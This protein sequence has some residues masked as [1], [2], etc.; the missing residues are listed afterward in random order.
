MSDHKLISK[1]YTEYKPL[2][3][4]NRILHKLNTSFELTAN[5]HFIPYV[6]YKIDKVKM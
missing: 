3:S 4:V 5:I 1:H 6:S 2:S